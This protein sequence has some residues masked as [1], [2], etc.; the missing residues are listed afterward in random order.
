MVLRASSYAP[1]FYEISVRFV[2]RGTLGDIA[3]PA[4]KVDYGVGSNCPV[5]TD[6]LLDVIYAPDQQNVPDAKSDPILPP[7][8][9]DIPGEFGLDPGE[10]DP[11]TKL[12]V[13]AAA[14]LGVAVAAGYAVRSFK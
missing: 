5:N 2:Y 6:W 4:R 12:L 11:S 9:S 13:G 3:W 14:V 10:W 1:A 7:Q 8:Y